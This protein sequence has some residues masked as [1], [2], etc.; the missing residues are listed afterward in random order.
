MSGQSP[1]MGKDGVWSKNV[2]FRL[3]RLKEAAAAGD[4]DVDQDKATTPTLALNTGIVPDTLKIG[5]I[6]RIHYRL[7]FA[8]AVTFT[9]RIWQAAIAADYESNLNMLYESPPLQA[10]DIDYDEAELDIPFV[11]ANEGIMFYSIDWTGACGNIQGFIEVSG[12][13]LE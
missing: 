10:D 11:L 6:K 4:F 2:A 5:F 12:E 13:T 1:T 9:L 3:F 8:G 7:N